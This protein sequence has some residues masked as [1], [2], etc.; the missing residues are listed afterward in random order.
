MYWQQAEWK[1]AYHSTKFEALF[2]PIVEGKLREGP[3]KKNDVRAVYLHGGVS[4]YKAAGYAT[5]NP[6]CDDGL[7]YRVGGEVVVYRSSKLDNA[8]MNTDQ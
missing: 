4:S 7:L 6:V 1:T 8:R 3:R 2:N 5:W